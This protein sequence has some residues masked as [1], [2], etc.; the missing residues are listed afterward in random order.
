MMG[1]KH[2]SQ[3]PY[4]LFNPFFERL[5]KVGKIDIDRDIVAYIKSKFNKIDYYE[6]CFFGFYYILSTSK[7]YS[8]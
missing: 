2:S 4:K 1:I 5:Y 7:S 6:E 3:M 8:T